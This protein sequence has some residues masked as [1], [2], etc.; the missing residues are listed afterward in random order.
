MRNAIDFFIP[1]TQPFA[2][3][4]QTIEMSGKKVRNLLHVDQDGLRIAGRGSLAD[5]SNAHKAMQEC[6]QGC[7]WFLRSSKEKQLVE[8]PIQLRYIASDIINLKELS[9]IVVITTEANLDLP[10]TVERKLLR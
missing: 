7:R 10:L 1:Q 8:I 4:I 2:S 6:P 5:P 9:G 3:Q